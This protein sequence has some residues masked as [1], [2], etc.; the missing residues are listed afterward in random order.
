[1]ND[2]LEQKRKQINAVSIGVSIYD[3][4]NI[5][6]YSAGYSNLATKAKVDKNSFYDI[7]SIG[8]LFTV[9]ATFMLIERNLLRLNTKV[10]SILDDLP[11]NWDEIK[12]NHLLTHTSGIKDYTDTKEYWKEMQDDVSKKRILDYILNEPLQFNTGTEFQY[13]NT[14]MFLLGLVIEK[15]TNKDYFHFIRSEILEKYQID[16]IIKTNNREKDDRKIVGYSISNN[17]FSEI[18]YYS[19]SGTFSAGGFSAKL[20]SFMKFERLLFNGDIISKEYVDQIITPWIK[21]N[22]QV[23]V[24]QNTKIGHGLFLYDLNGIKVVGHGGNI[25]GFSSVYFRFLSENIGIILCTNLDNFAEI[26]SLL[27][28]VYQ[29]YKAERYLC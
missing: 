13:N 12:I 21:P 14:G 11:S 16:G 18:E 17:E 29:K 20:N 1:M 25:R 6:F 8:K 7:A 27:F 26:H 10:T 22:G 4:E 9:A 28:D 23:L 19:N 24:V 15:I 5:Q 2:F 3:K